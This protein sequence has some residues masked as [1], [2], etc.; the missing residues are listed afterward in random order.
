MEFTHVHCLPVVVNSSASG[1]WDINFK[2]SRFNFIDWNIIRNSDNFVNSLF[3][4][5]AAPYS[6][7]IDRH[8]DGKT[9]VMSPTG[10]N[11]KRFDF[12]ITFTSKALCVHWWYIA[13]GMS[14]SFMILVPVNDL[15]RPRL[16]SFRY[17][18]SD[19][20][21]AIWSTQGKTHF[22]PHGLTYWIPPCLECELILVF[23]FG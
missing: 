9:L 11:T 7:H 12:L 5:D 4:S 8:A 17:L 20:W 22:K 21:L 6:D 23:R 10:S 13:T 1:T 18:F 15:C 19:T 14:F 3:H 2:V 16:I